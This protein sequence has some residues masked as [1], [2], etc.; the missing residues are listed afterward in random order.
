L[1]Q[2]I[3]FYIS[4]HGF[5][6]ASRSIEV[7]NAILVQ[8][9]ETRIGVRTSV[10]RWLFDLTVKGKVTYSS[11][12][13]DTG[14]VQA[15]ALTL[16]EADSIRRASAFHSDLVTRAA[17]ETRALRELGAGLIVGDM[18][19]LAF[20]VGAS[21]GIPSIGLGNFTW[22]W[23]YA[24]YPR[25]RLAP[26][27]LPAIRGAYA[28]ASMALRLPMSGGF[29]SF[30]NV[31]DIPFIA[32]HASRPRN[33]VCKILRMPADKP[34]VLVSFGGFSLSG[35]ETDV[36]A[37]SK[38]YTFVMSSQTPSARGR[39]ETSVSQKKGSL[40]TIHE[41]AMYNAGV[42][43]EDVVGA[44]DAVVT[45]PG[46]GIVSECIA[47]DTAMLYTSRGHFAEYD[48]LIE[49]IPKH[50]RAAFI[51][52][53]DLYSGK[54]EPALN[55]LLAQPKPEKKPDTNGAEVAAEMLLKAL[56]K[57]PRKPRGRPRAKRA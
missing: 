32:R 38:K 5:G 15:D 27:L 49:E 43:Y 53:D 35:I 8:R 51:S 28:K 16:D 2:A 36:L 57:P 24:D 54:W 50:L 37:K 23:I 30:S 48:V 39:R 12:E 47:N 55:K 18:P 6:H 17:S 31:K 3:V 22:D 46:Y 29:E 4:G 52:H 26:A 9:P 45:K 10:P 7:I 41:E 25:V 11:L 14:V 34:I 13:C 42:R 44:A 19:P 21:S 20:A 56:D 1:A 40:I 33:E